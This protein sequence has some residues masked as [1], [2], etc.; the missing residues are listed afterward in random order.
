MAALAKVGPAG[1]MALGPVTDPAVAAAMRIQTRISSAA[2]FARPMLFPVLACRLVS[3]SVEHGLSPATPY[4][5][6]VYG[7]VLNSLGRLP[8]AHGWGQVALALLP[9]FEDQSL[10]A[11]TQHVVHDLVGTWT[12]PL[13]STLAD[14]RNVVTVGKETGD[15]EYAAYAAHAYVHNAFYAGRELEGLLE[16]ALAFGAFM[17]GYGQVNA[18]H[19]HAPFEQAIRC[20]TGRAADPSRL[21]GEGFDEKAAIDVALES[22]SRSAVAI[23][24]ILMGIV[25][26]HFGTIA[27]ASACFERARPYLDGVVSTW[28]TP[29]FHQYAALSI[30]RLPAEARKK[31]APAADASLAALRALAADGPMNFAHRVLLVEAEQARADGDHEGAMGKCRGAIAGAEAGAWHADAAIAHDLA[32]RCA[33][34]RG[35]GGDAARHQAA[36]RDAYARWGAVR[37]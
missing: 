10:A 33:E 30:H 2:Y 13:A 31:L 15:L 25:R 20:F 27:D 21:D 17:R 11:R 24:G 6:S 23:V 14:L 36:A 37:G 1:L 5:L 34:A 16:E 35:E 26:F 29:M 22:G 4:A 12:V 18:L 7:V 32:A 28:H 9:R 19:V 3:T 8:E